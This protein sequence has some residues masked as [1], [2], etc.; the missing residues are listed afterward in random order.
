MSADSDRRANCRG[1]TVGPAHASSGFSLL[2]VLAA[3]TILAFALSALYNSFGTAIRAR[4]TATQRLAATQLAQSLLSQQI[5]NR[6]I[7]P[8]VSSG[9]VGMYQWLI[10]IR[11]F[12]VEPPTPAGDARSRL[13][14]KEKDRAASP[15]PDQ[16]TLFE[17]SIT[18]SWPRNRS[19]R[20]D[21]LHLAKVP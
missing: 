6:V 12:E 5:L 20:L 13:E 11:P 7:E 14:Q 18:V 10:S 4:D 1:R 8:A 17:I 15:P 19:M 9:R 16:W 3:L 21:T 2:E